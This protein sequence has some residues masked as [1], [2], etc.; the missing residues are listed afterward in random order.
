MVTEP[1][2]ALFV[3]LL[4]EGG[5]PVD[6]VRRVGV[7]SDTGMDEGG[8]VGKSVDTDGAPVEPPVGP[9]TTPVPVWDGGKMPEVSLVL[10]TDGRVPEGV[11]LGESVGVSVTTGGRPVE[12]LGTGSTVTAGPVPEGGGVL[13]GSGRISVKMLEMMLG[14]PD[15]GA[16]GPGRTSDMPDSEGRGNSG[17]GVTGP[18]EAVS[19]V[20][21]GRPTVGVGESEIPK[22]VVIPTRI[23]V[24]VVGMGR[25][26][27]VEVS[28]TLGGTTLGGTPPVEPTDGVGSGVGRMGGRDS[29]T[30]NEG[31]TIVSGRPPVEDRGGGRMKGPRMDVDDGTGSLAEGK[32]AV[33]VTMGSG[34]PPVDPT[35]EDAEG[36]TGPGMRIGV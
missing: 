4:G 12:P 2:D 20:G 14:S 10:I 26:T 16:V 36:R 17:V 8:D 28:A 29:P 23:P 18:S 21:I 33:G 32:D 22:A 35:D 15:E 3:P 30:D 31:N 19:D 6:W 1:V 34:T 9:G 24:P 5:S 7:V 27:S 11:S 25:R 13:L